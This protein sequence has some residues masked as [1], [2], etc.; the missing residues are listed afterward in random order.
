M[1]PSSP[2]RKPLARAPA[3]PAPPAARPAPA[4][5]ESLRVFP[6]Q[7]RP[8]DLVTDDQG[9]EW[10]VSRHSAFY[11]QGKTHVVRMQTPGDPSTVWQH[12]WPAHV[13]IAIRRPRRAP[14]AR[15]DAASEAP[16]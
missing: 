11:Q 10:E 12:V 15:G 5:G 2:K 6:S 3:K 8:R 16:G 4:A 1:T 14:S 9:A 13:R 7:L